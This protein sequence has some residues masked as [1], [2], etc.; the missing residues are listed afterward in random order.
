M[1]NGKN[2]KIGIDCRLIN[3]TGVGRYTRNLVE[4]LQKQDKKNTYVLIKT[5]IKWHTLKEQLIFPWIIWRKKC[6]LVHFPYF[7]I[8]VFYPGKFIVTIH[9]LII[10]HFDTGR[11]STKNI[12]IYKGK[13]WFYILI[14]WLVAHRACKIITVSE[15]TKREIVEHLGIKQEKVVVTYEGVTLDQKSKIKNQNESPYFLYVGNAYPHKNL[16][17]LILAFN[18][19]Q[20]SKLVLVGK[21]D[22]FYRRLKEHIN[23]KKIEN[24]IFYNEITDEELAYLYQHAM[25]LIHPSLMEGFGLTVVEAMANGCLVACADIPS[26]REITGGHALF[27]DPNST[28]DM[29]KKMEQIISM[30]YDDMRKKAKEWVKKYS[31]EKMAKETKKIYE[32]CLGL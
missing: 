16:E 17:K 31:W 21:E 27:F 20:N 1:G 14:I 13:R 10:N 2:M 8:P 29:K 22:Y 28:E 25:A 12:F 15:S 32:N 24:I 7:S 5:D 6:D 26:L 9:D 4:E 30:N 11:A 19:I 3:E 23:K 18:K